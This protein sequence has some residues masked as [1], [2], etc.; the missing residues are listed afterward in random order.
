M[1][2]RAPSRMR[3]IERVRGALSAMVWY[4]V[5]RP[6]GPSGLASGAAA[7]RTLAASA[8][9]ANV[10]GHV[11]ANVSGRVLAS[12]H[13]RSRCCALETRNSTDEGRFVETSAAAVCSSPLRAPRRSSG[14]V[15]AVFAAGSEGPTR[16]F[17]LSDGHSGSTS[18]LMLL[19]QSNNV[20]TMC[21]EGVWACEGQQLLLKERAVASVPEIDAASLDWRDV[22][23]R[24]ERAWARGEK[25]LAAAQRF[26]RT[27][28]IFVDKSPRFAGGAAGIAQEAARRG[29]RCAFL[30]LT[31]FVCGYSPAQATRHAADWPETMGKLERDWRD[32]VAAG[33]PV[34]VVR[35]EDLARDPFQVARNL[36][37]WLPT[38]GALDPARSP[39]RL[40]LFG[41]KRLKALGPQW[42][43]RMLPIAKY[44]N[45]HPPSL[46]NVC[47]DLPDLTAA[48]TAVKFGYHPFP[49]GGGGDDD[50]A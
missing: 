30:L 17:V 21:G 41:P 40:R 4:G 23:D 6:R 27:A 3:E 43:T 1:R 10:N 14:A 2:A 28:L 24:F 48:K 22:Y 9:V 20:V 32:A 42:T 8:V 39:D 34:H 46:E 13:C 16:L 49:A 45:A 26:N 37:L 18:L 33:A 5:W 11:V 35:Y 12:C 50:D 29:V 15:A 31:R 7:A 25:R 44:F 38:L 19:A 36:S 47:A